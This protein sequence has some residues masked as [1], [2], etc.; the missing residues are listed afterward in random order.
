MRLSVD[1][2]KLSYRDWFEYFN[3]L[4]L[5]FILCSDCSVNLF[6]FGTEG[7]SSRSPWARDQDSSRTL[8]RRPK[9]FLTR[10]TPMTRS[11]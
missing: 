9:I 5:A 3:E 6:F 10:T 8:A 7:R 11:S 4:I 2:S 1:H